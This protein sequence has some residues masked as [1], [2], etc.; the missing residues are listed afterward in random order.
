MPIV[1]VQPVY[2]PEVRALCC[3]PY[4]GHPKGCPNFGHAERC[5][6]HAPLL[7]EVFDLK[8]EVF[9]IYNR[10]DLGAHVAKM[11]NA[12]PD[13]GE[14]QLVCCLYWQGT[15][16]GQLAKEIARI[17][18]AW[19]EKGWTIL[20]TPEACG[21]NITATMAAIGVRLQWPPQDYTYQIA[22]VGVTRS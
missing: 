5:P 3:K 20:H 6:P 11:R 13:W 1:Q 9:A 14:R 8:R 22:L 18:R 16:R 10:F 7:P 17:T 4:P 19:P 2:Q 12:H 15:A 21:V